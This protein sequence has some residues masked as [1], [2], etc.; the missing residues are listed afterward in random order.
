MARRAALFCAALFDV[1]ARERA[2]IEALAAPGVCA[3]A[4]GGG[5]RRRGRG[6]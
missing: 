4:A 6:E 3:G 1:Q 5:K 2:A